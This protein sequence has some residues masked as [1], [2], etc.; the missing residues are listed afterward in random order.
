MG[1][2]LLLGVVSILIGIFFGLLSSY[3]LKTMRFITVSSVRETL[4]ILCF[5]FISYTVSLLID[6]S[7]IISLLTC[8]VVLA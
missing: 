1:E 6:M 3:L 4:F 7:G 5:A 2:F 8:G